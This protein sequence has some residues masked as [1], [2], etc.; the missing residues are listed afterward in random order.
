MER[1]RKGISQE[2]MAEQLGI[3]QNVYS[4]IERGTVKLDIE[5]LHQIA[6][7][8]DINVKVELLTEKGKDK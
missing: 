7:I 2:Y 6:V 5:R 1:I 3:S 8:L 4:R